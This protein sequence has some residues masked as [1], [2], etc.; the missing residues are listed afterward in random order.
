MDKKIVNTRREWNRKMDVVIK[1]YAQEKN[2]TYNEAFEWLKENHPQT[3]EG[4]LLA[5]RNSK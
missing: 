3:I 1:G 4:Y 5:L 2:L